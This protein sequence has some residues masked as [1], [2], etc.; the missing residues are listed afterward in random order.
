[1]SNLTLYPYLVRPGGEKGKLKVRASP[2]PKN[3]EP[4]SVGTLAESTGR[5]VAALPPS[6]FEKPLTCCCAALTSVNTDSLDQLSKL[7]NNPTVVMCTNSKKA[8]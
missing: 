5:P 8:K 3:V 4:S 6:E 2:H 1:M 7:G